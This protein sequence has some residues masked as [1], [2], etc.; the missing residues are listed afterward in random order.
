MKRIF[1]FLFLFF[2]CMNSSLAITPLGGY[3]IEGENPIMYPFVDKENK[4]IT[5]FSSW[6]EKEVLNKP[7]RVIET[8]V[9]LHYKI[10]NTTDFTY[11]DYYVDSTN[12]PLYSS[13]YLVEKI[14]QRR[15]KDYLYYYS[16]EPISKNLATINLFRF[17][18]RTLTSSKNVKF[19]FA[20]QEMILFL[21]CL[22]LIIFLIL[23]SNT[24]KKLSYKNKF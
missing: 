23:K 20:F 9:L 5:S 14:V 8:R 1:F 13:E 17:S 6:T 18:N 15:Y 12:G 3:Y 21:S 10:L 16:K 2:S 24:A 22:F 7:N 11:K 4:K 19:L